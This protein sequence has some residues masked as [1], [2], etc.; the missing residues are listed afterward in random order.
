[1]LARKLRKPPGDN[2]LYQPFAITD[3]MRGACELPGLDPLHIANEGQ[4]LAVIAAEYADAALQTL[5]ETPGGH[6]A[7]IVGEIGEQPAATVLGT[8][9]YG[10]TRVID[11]LV[12]DPVVRKNSVWLVRL[13]AETVTAQTRATTIATRCSRAHCEMAR[14]NPTW[15][16]ER[17][18]DELKVKRKPTISGGA[19][20]YATIPKRSSSVTSSFQPRR[21][22]QVLYELCLS[23]HCQEHNAANKRHCA[24]DGR[25]GYIMCL[26][27]GSVN[28]SDVDNLFPGRVRK[29]S[30]RKT[31]QAKRNQDYSKRFV[32]DDLRRRYAR[33]YRFIYFSSSFSIWPTFFWTLPAIFSAWPSASRLGL[34]VTCPAFSLALPFIS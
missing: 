29:T 22:F 7:E 27:A 8:A 28:R 26:V 5:R 31:E 32:H 1:M 4:F 13:V 33:G 24:C 30:P 18:A 19:A 12:G 11:M 20:S 23:G 34:L 25:Q 6:S 2:I 16:E 9:D 10:D 14:E 3:A 17:I 15:G 21:P